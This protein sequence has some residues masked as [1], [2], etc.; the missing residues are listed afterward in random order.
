MSYSIPDPIPDDATPEQ[1]RHYV[2]YWRLKAQGYA[3]R[4]NL[5][6]Q[7]GDNLKAEN[8][9]LR[10]AGDAMA[11]QVWKNC[12]CEDCEELCDQWCDAKRG[13]QPNK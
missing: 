10:K 9:R 4:W 11:D 12:G 1:L 7:Y 6:M 3:F 2:N 5:A 13:E 8:A